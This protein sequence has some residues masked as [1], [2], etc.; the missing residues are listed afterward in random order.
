M[1]NDDVARL[2]PLLQLSKGLLERLAV[3]GS[4]R[5]VQVTS[6]AG[7]TV[8]QVMDA[9]GDREELL[10]ALEHHPAGIDARASQVAD[11]KVQY[12]GDPAA[13]ARSS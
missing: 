1:Q 11:Q 8:E 2:D 7:L 4:C 5:L 10:A 6:V 12:L 3:A 13:P 9:L